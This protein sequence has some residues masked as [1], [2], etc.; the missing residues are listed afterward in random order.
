MS[1]SRAIRICCTRMIDVVATIDGV[2]SSPQFST[3]LC[4]ASAMRSVAAPPR[5]EVPS[6]LSAG[7]TGPRLPDAQAGGV[8]SGRGP[9]EPTGKTLERV[10]GQLPE[11]SAEE[12][13]GDTQQS[14]ELDVGGV[15]DARAPVTG[16]LEH[17][18]V[19]G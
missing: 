14:L 13:L 17:D 16:R 8:A 15:G 5:A 18:R 11:G 12:R 19:K 2:A 9:A 10:V 6:S 1:L 7:F 4:P 3:H